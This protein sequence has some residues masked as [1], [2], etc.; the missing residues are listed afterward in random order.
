MQRES[1]NGK[2][3][4]DRHCQ[5]A[6]LG[7]DVSAKAAGFSR[8]FFQPHAFPALIRRLKQARPDI[9]IAC[10]GPSVHDVMGREL[11]DKCDAIDAVCLGEADEILSPLSQISA[12]G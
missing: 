3:Q 4:Q 11:M 12:F 10:G 7:P 5:H 6:L 1:R 2:P 8:G 9:K